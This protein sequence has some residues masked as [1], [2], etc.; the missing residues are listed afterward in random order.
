MSYDSQTS[1]TLI[2]KLRK[3]VD[4]LTLKVAV[5]TDSKTSGTSGGNGV[6]AVF[7]A[8]ELN[9]IQSDPNGLIIDLTGNTFKLA[10]GSYQ[11]RNISA[12]LHTGHT[13]MR[14][15]D[16]TNAVVIGYSVSVEV[17]NQANL[18]LDMNVRIIPHKD[19]I[20]RIEY[21]ITASGADHLGVAASLPSIDEIYSVC[22]IT[23]LDTGMTKPLGTGGLQGP[24]GPAG[25]T[26]PSGP[27]GPS[28]GGVTSVNVSGGATGLSTSGGPITTS[29]TITLGGIVAVT[30]GGTG[31]ITAPAALTS[32]G[33]YPASNPSGYTSNVGTVTSTSV[34][35]AAGVSGTV[36]NPTTTPAITIVLGAITPTSVA[37]T[38]TV[39]GTNI[40]GSTSGANT[41]D[42]IITLTG[43]VT[44]TGTTTFATTIT[45]QAVT[46][47]KIQLAGA[48]KRLLGSDGTGTSI[49]EINLGANLAMTGNTLSASAPGTGTVT[50]VNADGSTTGMSFTGGPVTTSG[51]L[52]LGGT[53]ALTNG[54]TGAVSA[55]AALTSLGAY[56]AANPSGFTSNAGTVTT[57]S[58]TTANGVSGTV[59]NP[60]S[61]PAITI[62]LGAIVPTSVA[63]TGTVTG[64]NLSGTHTGT[65]S[66]TNTGDQAI[67]LSGDVSGSGSTGIT[68][69][70]AANAVTYAKMQAIS[71]S[72]KLLGS[73]ASGTAVQEITLGSN[74]SMAGSTLNAA[75]ASGSVTSVNAD[76]GTTGFSFTGGPITS[77]GTLSMTGTLAVASGGTGAATA[78]NAR[79]NLGL[80][81]GTDIPSPTGTGATGTWNIDV[82]GSAGTITSTLPIANG[83]TGATTAPV[84]LTNLGAYPAANPAGYTANVGTVT[85]VS[86]SGSAN[87]SVATGSTTPVISQVGASTTQNGFMSS[88][89]AT[90]LDGITTGASV[91]SVAVSG[92]TTG[93]TT[94]GG[95]ITTFGTITMAGTL[96]VANGGTGLTAVGAQYQVLTSTGSAATW[97][98]VDLN[99]ST[100]N[101]LPI[102]KGGTASITAQSAMDT[103]AGAQTNGQYL[104][105]NGT[106]VVMSAVQA[107]DLPQIALGGSAVSGTLGVIN[108]GTGLSNVYTN[109]DLLIGNTTGSTLSRNKIV[110]TAPITVTNGAGTITIGAGG[111]GT[112]DVV[113]PGSA[114]DGNFALYDGATGKLIKGS[115]WNQVAGDLIGSLGYSS[116]VDGFV[117]IPAD[118]AA[119]T[120]TPTNVGA[121]PV[122]VPMYLQ[123]NNAANTNVLWV[124][125]GFAWKYVTLT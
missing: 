78:P 51:T 48:I 122:N 6:A 40:S 88:T 112:G 7:T 27:P 4:S 33:A 58:V 77:S 30:A 81:I 49:G 84:A 44:G 101:V 32:L 99:N 76:G 54:G 116:M 50:S 39:T 69:T 108:G 52:T 124:H 3:D 118:A 17:S 120:G 92:G 73:S 123:T 75:V 82:L 95:P 79:T 89:Q 26:G 61:T 105:G 14:V 65:S 28:G 93:L 46:Y 41:G 42:Q 19:T 74:L 107:V 55:A 45:N 85:N 1:T 115:G 8:R 35:T 72:S 70:I 91:T 67:V 83:G 121:P 53:L 47:D 15:Y 23:R 38:G 125:N 36:A 71:A 64:S 43:P 103:L 90:K 5:L 68:T 86:V 98:T 66:G 24:Q 102:A 109:G 59:A 87:I 11:V 12:F 111:L 114:S 104:R 16:V 97:T 96:A 106:N 37:S 100:S 57:A 2:N 119:P 31:A 21:Y 60:T 29:G 62:V 18:Y 25:P 56:P 110:G 63:A 20:Y 10:A 94:S 13:R 9:T 117:Y 34:T 113:G 22:E 80:V